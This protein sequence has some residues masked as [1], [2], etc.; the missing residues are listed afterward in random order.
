M[1][2]D[3]LDIYTFQRLLEDA[4][5]L[6]P[7]TV[8]K[9]QGAIIWDTLSVGS[10]QLAEAYIQLK[11][12]YL[13]TNVLTAA[14]EDLDL[15]VAERGISRL[16]ATSAVKLAMFYGTDGTPAAVPLG[17]RF[18]TARDTNALI[19]AVSGIYTNPT[20]GETVP[21][22]YRLTCETP[23]TV[24]NDYIGALIPVTFLNHVATATMSDL[25]I[26]GREVESDDSLR[27][28]YLELVNYPP[29]GGNVSQYRQWVLQMDGVGAVQIFPVWQ[30]GGTV[31]VNIL[32]A[33]YSPASGTLIQDVQTAMDP[34]TNH[35]EGLGLAPIGHFVTVGTPSVLAINVEAAISLTNATIAQVQTAVEAAI[36]FYLLSLRRDFGASIDLLAHPIPVYRAR[37]ISEILSVPGVENVTNLLLNGVD[38]DMLLDASA[39]AQQ[40]PVDGTVILHEV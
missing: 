4:L 8:D 2:G 36:S 34:E 28:R 17:S 29:F 38:A 32:G 30:G 15:K 7:D 40:I 14:G 1:I 3:H 10:V 6:V 16:E 21:G 18:S 37:I 24:G 9:R 20:T 35:G 13:S 19:Y 26:P 31:K 11:G 27:G 25:L 33:D 39:V 23:G 5:R 12:F 22:G